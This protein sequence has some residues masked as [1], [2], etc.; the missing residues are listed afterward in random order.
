MAGHLERR[1]EKRKKRKKRH[2]T[3]FKNILL[4]LSKYADQNKH[5]FKPI[6]SFTKIHR[7]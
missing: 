3:A 6:N 7:Y 4:G 1:E 2:V 5:F